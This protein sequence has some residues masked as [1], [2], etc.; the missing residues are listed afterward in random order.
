MQQRQGAREGIFGRRPGERIDCKRIERAGVAHFCGFARPS[1][2][3]DHVAALRKGR[4]KAILR[5]GVARFSA[6]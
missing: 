1:I 2:R 3:T 5:S 6:S 4:R